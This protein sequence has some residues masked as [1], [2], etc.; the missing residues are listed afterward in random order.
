MEALNV[1]S[2][3][4][5]KIKTKRNGKNSKMISMQL[6][7][8]ILNAVLKAMKEENVSLIMKDSVGL[9]VIISVVR[10]KE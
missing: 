6:L 5:R 7:A 4:Y 10:F 1:L 8:Q 9:S 3:R 2:F